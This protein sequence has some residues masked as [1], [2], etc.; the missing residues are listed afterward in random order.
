MQIAPRNGLQRLAHVAV[1][2]PRLAQAGGLCVA[3][4]MADGVWSAFDAHQAGATFVG[5][6][7]QSDGEQAGAGIQIPHRMRGGAERT[8][9][10]IQ[11]MGHQR[12]RRLAVDLPETIGAHLVLQRRTGR[13]DAGN[14]FDERGVAGDEFPV[15]ADGVVV[16]QRLLA[17]VDGWS[18]YADLGAWLEAA[19]P[20][21][22]FFGCVQDL[23]RRQR[24]SV[25][26]HAVVAAAPTHGRTTVVAGD[27]LDARAPV[28]PAA[29][30]VAG[31]G[32]QLDVGMDAAQAFHLLIDDRLLPGALAFQAD[33]D[34]V[35]AAETAA[36]RQRSRRL[37]DRVDAPARGTG[38]VH[39]LARPETVAAVMR[40][41]QDN[42]VNLAGQSETHEH[43]ATVDV[44]DATPLVGEPLDFDFLLH[45]LSGHGRLPGGG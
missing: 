18:G 20:H 25:D 27:H 9:G 19:V 24:H 7:P 5:H 16:S 22:V 3:A 4:G 29:L 11:H 32:V 2:D 1:A 12:G 28:Q 15:D 38:D 33:V 36:L 34:Q 13:A 21:M 44:G 39:D 41:V 45:P 26:R 31:H 43:D 40:L 17:F 35:R 30:R 23:P 37:P 10:Q 42:A 8:A 6:R 14:P